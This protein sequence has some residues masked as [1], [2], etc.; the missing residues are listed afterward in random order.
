M[1][2]LKALLLIIGCLFFGG[3]NLIVAA[4][5]DDD[6]NPENPAEPA[7]IDYCRV[8]VSTNYEEGSYVSGGGKYLVNGGSIYISTNANNTP[9]YTYNFL[10][11]TMNGVKT[12][13]SQDF[14]FTA[15]KGRFDF[16]A[17]YEKVDTPFEPES[18]DE[19]SS[20]NV[21]RK[22][23][24][25]ITSN[26]EGACSFNI[27]SGNKVQEQSQFYVEAYPN[28][29]YQ[30]DCWKLNNQIVS[31]DQWF[32]FTMP[33][34]TANLEAC[35]SEIPF[36]P[37]S[38][39]EPTSSGGNVDNSSRKLINLTIGT[40]DN[41]VDKTR[42]V[43]NEA[44]TSGY[45]TGT[46]VAKMVSTSANYQ[47]YSLD[48]ENVKYSVNERPQDDGVIP[49]GIVVKKAGSVI[50]SATRL[51]CT[52]YLVDKTTDYW[53]DLS[54]KGYTFNSEAGTFENRFYI[55]VG[56]IPDIPLVK[57]D[58]KTREYGDENPALTYTIENGELTGTPA[59][60]TT[61]NKQSSVGT[62]PITI[63][64]GTIQG[65]Y[66]A[67]E[68]TLT[69]TNAPLTISGR[70]YIIV[71][72]GTIPEFTLDYSGF[73]N[74]ETASVLTTLPT[75]TTTATANSAPGAYP[76]TVS[77]GKAQNYDLSYTN[78]TLIILAK[79]DANGDGVID[80]QDA[81]K[82]VQYYL[83]KNP[84]DF[85]TEAADVNNDG[86]VDTQDAIQIIKIYLKK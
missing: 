1:M 10:Y 53:H 6:Y 86:V 45:D 65:A 68:G 82:V 44:K 51:D 66:S 38:P 83:G 55:K 48:A 2:K 67:E 3:G 77:G 80:T 15:Q 59:L 36:D 84:T 41:T 4:S 25:Y 63:S 13:Y 40:E 16:V 54:K 18:P 29:G 74:N 43:I 72:G 79:G 26:I 71:Q 11:W 70:T 32:Y 60:S 37:E 85:Y 31:H 64:K 23:Y 17:H 5:P 78:G 50:I 73:K 34:K 33:S 24:L 57:A 21:K 49:L 7:V 58:N 62:Y 27:A 28:Q 20:V 69:I 30:F 9:D 8:T 81:I 61:A 76:V 19:P 46:D 14:Y 56:A 22:Y 35:F 12:S 42:I 47:L 75:A 52:A 39:Q